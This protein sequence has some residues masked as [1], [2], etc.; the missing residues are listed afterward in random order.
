MSKSAAGVTPKSVS[1]GESFEDRPGLV[2]DPR[3]LTALRHCRGGLAQWPE[4]FR[5]LG[6]WGFSGV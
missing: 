1:Q 5:G 4:G 2:P 6:F 3:N